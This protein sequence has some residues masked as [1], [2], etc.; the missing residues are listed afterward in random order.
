LPALRR[1]IRQRQR[2]NS[3][4]K[5]VYSS[6]EFLQRELERIYLLNIRLTSRLLISSVKE[7]SDQ[8]WAARLSRAVQGAERLGITHVRVERIVRYYLIHSIII[9]ILYYHVV[10]IYAHRGAQSW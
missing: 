4:K 10:E 2:I 3:V 1:L 7:E 8:A 6:V 9:Y 5:S